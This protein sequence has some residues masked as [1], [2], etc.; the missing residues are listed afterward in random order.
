MWV[1]TEVPGKHAREAAAV[2]VQRTL[3]T[4]SI[5]CA[6]LQIEALQSESF[7]GP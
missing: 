3:T 1:E 7:L 4:V 6:L 2:G 5:I